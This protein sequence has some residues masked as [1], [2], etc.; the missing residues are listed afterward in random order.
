[1]RYPCF[2]RL[3]SA[4]AN[5]A[6]DQAA[7]EVEGK[8]APSAKHLKPIVNAVEMV[9]ASAAALSATF[10]LKVS[11]SSTFSFHNCLYHCVLR[12]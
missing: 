7:T 1:M 4:V 5:A 6:A 11:L 12:M 2:C 3:Q 8:G 9:F 10:G